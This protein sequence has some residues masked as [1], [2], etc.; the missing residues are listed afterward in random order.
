MPATVS[1][2]SSVYRPIS[3]GAR[4]VSDE[5]IRMGNAIDRVADSI[6]RSVAL[7]GGYHEVLAELAEVADECREPGWDG[8]AAL[9]LPNEA[10]VKAEQFL[11]T[12]PACVRSPE[13]VPEPDGSVALIWDEGRR[14]IFSVSLQ[15]DPRVTYALLDGTSKAHGVEYFDGLSIPETLLDHIRRVTRPR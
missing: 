8:Y 11:Y 7:N 5:S 13:I 9:P 2:R 10:A 6:N 1:L 3:S 15:S 14:R 12:L 4:G